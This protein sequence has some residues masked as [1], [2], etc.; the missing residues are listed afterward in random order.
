M[1]PEQSVISSTNP[2]DGSHF[3]AARGDGFILI[4]NPYGK[5]FDINL[6]KI[7]G[8]RLNCYWYNP[9]EGTSLYIGKFNPGKT[10]VTFNAP[11]EDARGNDWV[12]VIDDASKKYPIPGTA[13]PEYVK[14]H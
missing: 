10:P 3:Q 9:R 8:K 7:S 1:V 4:Y 13:L 2:A 6:D 14:K 11:G 5:T 12:L